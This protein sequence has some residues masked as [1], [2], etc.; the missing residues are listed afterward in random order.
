[1]ALLET[2]RGALGTQAPDFQ[3]RGTDGR[4]YRLKECAK[5]NGLV[6]MFI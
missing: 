2:P 1:M 5:K 6:V 4:E 3:L